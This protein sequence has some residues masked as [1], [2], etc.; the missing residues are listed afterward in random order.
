MSRISYRRAT[1]EN[2]ERT[3]KRMVALNHATF[4]PADARVILKY[5][6][7]HLGLA[8]EEER[9][10]AFEAERRM[11]DYT[12]TADKDTADLCQSC[13]SIARV[14][15]ERRT[16]EEWELL[17]AMHRGLYPLVDNQPMVP[18][19]G[20]RRTRAPQTESAADG[21]P[22]DNRHPMDKAILTPDESAAVRDVRV[23][24][25]VRRDATAEA[26]RALG[27]RRDPARQRSGL[28]TGD[29][30]RGLGGTGRLPHGDAYTIARTGETVS[31]TGKSLVYTG[32]QWR[33][34][35]GAAQ[36]NRGASAVRRARLEDDVG[37][38]GPPVTT[39]RPAST[40]GSPAGQRSGGVRHECSALKT[41]STGGGEDFWREPP[42]GEDRKTSER[43]GVKV[44]RVVAAR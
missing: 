16:K 37:N 27:D 6:A 35:S 12:Y 34:R 4:E 41:A 3:I 23:V 14:L 18:G 26:R 19:G 33:G 38:A 22:P 25:V 11:V 1:P 5:L 36:C 28:R 10:I 21:R 29:D 32:Y 17:V 20:F 24:G 8:P 39:T 13:H 9:P 31:R 42:A 44:T 7:D 30:H 2:W 40:S 43:A 15:S